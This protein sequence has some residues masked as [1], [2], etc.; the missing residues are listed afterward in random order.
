MLGEQ[1]MVIIG[2][3]E[4]LEIAPSKT[5]SASLKLDSVAYRRRSRGTH[6]DNN[7]DRRYTDGQH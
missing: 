6:N 7:G 5:S 4:S 1:S 2:H 3:G